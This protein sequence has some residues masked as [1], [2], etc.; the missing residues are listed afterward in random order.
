MTRK[1]LGRLST[2]VVA[3]AVFAG[4]GAMLAGP[5]TAAPAGGTASGA[6]GE[7]ASFGWQV[8]DYFFYTGSSGVAQRECMARGES[9]VANGSWSRFR[10]F[11]DGVGTIRLEA[12]IN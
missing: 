9:G 5:A 2:S 12:W 8:V 4:G 6:V 1:W 7:T 3:V 10:C 11:N